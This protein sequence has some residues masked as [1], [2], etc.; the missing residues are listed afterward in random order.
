MG[1]KEDR[2]REVLGEKGQQRRKWKENGAETLGLEEPQVIRN[3]IAGE[4]S[5]VW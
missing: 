4:Y 3:P 1:E 2:G 5:S